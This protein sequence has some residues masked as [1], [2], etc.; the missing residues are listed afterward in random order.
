MPIEVEM[1]SPTFTLSNNYK[2]DRFTQLFLG[3]VSVNLYLLD[4]L[5]QPKTNYSNE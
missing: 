3:K 1:A 2:T 4:N 5:N